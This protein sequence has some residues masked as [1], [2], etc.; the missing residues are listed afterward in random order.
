ML[1]ALGVA[2]TALLFLAEGR[3]AHEA[4]QTHGTRSAPWRDHER[5][6]AAD[7]PSETPPPGWKDILFRVYHNIWQHRVLSLAGGVT[8]Y[9]ILAIFPAIAALVSLYGLFADTGTV[10]STVDH[11]QGILPSGGIEVVQA[12]IVRIATQP[13]GTLSLGFI[14][15]L[16]F[17]LW[18]ANSAMTALFDALNIVYGER[19]KRSLAGLYAEALGF[20]SLALVFGLLAITAVV[21]LPPALAALE[22]GNGVEPFIRIARWPLML[23]VVALAL[24]LI[25][26]YGPSRE[27]ARWRWISWGSAVGA[28]AWLGASMLFSWYA[29]NFGRFNATYGSLGAIIGFM[30]W[31]WVSAIV[32][33]VGGELDAE[34]EHQT[35]KDSTTGAPE[36]MGARGAVMAD[37]LGPGRED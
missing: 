4:K 15:S 1:A 9:S 30:M 12:Q 3:H 22:L 36:P 33:L 21:A 18:S 32:I 13:H 31:I 25:Y 10:S 16:A 8:F 6:R 17:A 14:V 5:G 29:A 20:T 23:A 26:R 34:M 11:L 35:A 37:T 7:T 27:H 24:A 28:S 19:E 2:L